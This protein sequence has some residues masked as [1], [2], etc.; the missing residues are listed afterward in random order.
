ML[1]GLPIDVGRK[2]SASHTLLGLETCSSGGERLRDKVLSKDG[3]SRGATSESARDDRE[4]ARD[5]QERQMNE[6][7]KISGCLACNK[8]ELE[9]FFRKLDIDLSR[10]EKIGTPSSSLARTDVTI[11][12]QCDQAWRIKPKGRIVSLKGNVSAKSGS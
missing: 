6:K 4:G 3:E 10:F 8:A 11:C 12:D 9:D 1:L 7:K 2:M 5:D